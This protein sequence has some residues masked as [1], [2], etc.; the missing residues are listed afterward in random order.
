M[1]KPYKYIKGKEVKTYQDILDSVEGFIISDLGGN[2]AYDQAII[3]GMD[4]RISLLR[5]NNILEQGSK[6]YTREKLWRTPVFSEKLDDEL[7]S[8]I[9]DFGYDY[10]AE[11][12]TD[13]QRME[14]LLV[15]LKELLTNHQKGFPCNIGDTVYWALDDEGYS[16]VLEGK[17]SGLS[18]SQNNTTW[19]S[20]VY[21]DGL[22]FHHTFKDYWGKTVF[23]NKE[24][25]LAKLENLKK[26]ERL[27]CQTE[28][29]KQ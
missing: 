19:F 28:K 1:L 3:K 9:C 16:G 21:E 2:H 17:I 6:V 14:D 24:Q 18:I 11:E 22:S 23:I 12:Y 20:V 29:K 13:G 8:L 5:L 10:D 4:E 26:E 7:D 27:L 15:K 25:A